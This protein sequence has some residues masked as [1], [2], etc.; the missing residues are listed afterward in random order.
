MEHKDPLSYLEF[1][2][3]MTWKPNIA[4][5]LGLHYCTKQG[6]KHLQRQRTKDHW[7]FYLG[8]GFKNVL[9]S[10]LPVRW[11]NLTRIFQMGWNHQL[12]IDLHEFLV[13]TISSI[14]KPFTP[15]VFRTF[16]SWS[17]VWSDFP[18][19]RTAGLFQSEYT[20]GCESQPECD[21]P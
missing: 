8:L 11:S 13:L 1:L 21:R 14:F 20:Q 2:W 17:G 7:I 6:T 3:S 5:W 18:W 12:V 19:R 4:T 10:T 15:S 9:F 16:Q